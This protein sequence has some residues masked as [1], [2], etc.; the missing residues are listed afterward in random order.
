MKPGNVPYK[1][2]YI[3]DVDCN[4]LENS[5]NEDFDC[6]LELVRLFS[7]RNKIECKLIE[8][9]NNIEMEKWLK[10]NSSKTN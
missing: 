2:K 1:L 5:Y 8:N 10:N 9:K 3:L 6:N 4:I 7:I